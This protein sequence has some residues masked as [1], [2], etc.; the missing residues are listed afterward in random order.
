MESEG[1]E[2]E[3]GRVLAE[4]AGMRVKMKEVADETKQKEILYKQLVSWELMAHMMMTVCMVGGSLL[5]EFHPSPLA[6]VHTHTHTHAHTHT[7]THTPQ[8]SVVIHQRS[9]CLIPTSLEKPL[10]Q[11][12]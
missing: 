4:V 10:T 11:C 7:H 1:R 5:T 6:V 9:L 12:Q 3:E 8:S 2:S